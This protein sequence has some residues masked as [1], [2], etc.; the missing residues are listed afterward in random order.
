MT[1]R[2]KAETKR[3]RKKIGGKE[4]KQRLYGGM[5]NDCD[6]KANTYEIKFKNRGPNVDMD[7]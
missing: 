5:P 2:R 1:S 3:R 6:V 4:K 7:F